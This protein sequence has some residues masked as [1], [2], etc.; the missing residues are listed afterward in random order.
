MLRRRVTI[1]SQVAYL[2]FDYRRHAWAR[3]WDRHWQALALRGSAPGDSVALVDGE[4]AIAYDPD[5]CQVWII[6]DGIEGY[7]SP[8]FDVRV[9]ALRALENL[10]RLTF[11]GFN[12]RNVRLVA[13]VVSGAF[14]GIAGLLYSMRNMGAFPSMISP[15]TSLDGLIMCLIGGMYS[16]FGPIAGAAIMTVINVQLPNLTQYYQSILGFI[17]VLSVLFLQGV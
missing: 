2:P 14:C 6:D 4:A 16:F 3:S 17:I 7:S 13:Y 9:E 5:G 8:R 11:L 12:T 15:G 10:E 1:G